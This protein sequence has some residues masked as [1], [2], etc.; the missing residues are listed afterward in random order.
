[1][2]CIHQA[3]KFSTSFS[4]SEGTFTDSGVDDVCFVQTILHFTG[5]DFCQGFCNIHGYSSGFGIWHEALGSTNF[6]Q[7]SDN[8]H[9]VWGCN[10]HIEIKPVFSLDFLSKFFGTDIIR[11]GVF[12]FCGFRSLGKYQNLLVFPVPWGSTIAPLTCW[13]ACLPS[14]P[15]LICTSTVSSNFAFAFFRASSK[16]SVVSYRFALSNVFTDS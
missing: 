9:H 8:T 14:T 5:F 7:S 1:M 11:S 6:T 2:Y 16:A 13:S 15:S 10:D 12:C 3:V 4:G